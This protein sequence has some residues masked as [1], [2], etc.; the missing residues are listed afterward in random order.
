MQGELPEA[1]LYKTTRQNGH[2]LRCVLRYGVT[3]CSSLH[4]FRFFILVFHLQQKHEE[5]QSLLHY[6]R[7]TNITLATWTFIYVLNQEAC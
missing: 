4:L 3:L 2:N 7:Q 5:G 6:L 1:L